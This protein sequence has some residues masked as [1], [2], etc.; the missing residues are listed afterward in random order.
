VALAAMMCGAIL[1]P[2]LWLIA[3]G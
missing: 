2:L 3:H 1:F